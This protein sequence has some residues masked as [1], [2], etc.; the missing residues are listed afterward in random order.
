MPERPRRLNTYSHLWPSAEDR[1]REAAASLMS[2]VAGQY[3]PHRVPQASYL[4]N[5]DRSHVEAESVPHDRESL[6][7]MGTWP[8]T[9]DG[10]VENR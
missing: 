4:R 5:R 2:E 8:M 7:V 9:C 1:P 6:A 10:V 3:G